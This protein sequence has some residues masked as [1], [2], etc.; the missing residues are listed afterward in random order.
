M[1]SFQQPSSKVAVAEVHHNAIKIDFGGKGVSDVGE[2]TCKPDEGS[3][4]YV[5]SHHFIAGE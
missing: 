1:R 2:T 3:L 5:F 4:G